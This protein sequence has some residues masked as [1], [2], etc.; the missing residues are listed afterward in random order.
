MSL[1]PQ[2]QTPD[3]TDALD[4]SLT[5]WYENVNN[6][7][8]ASE[9][10][11]GYYEY[12]QAPSYGNQCPIQEGGSTKIDIGCSR[13]EIIDLDNSYIDCTFTFPLTIPPQLYKGEKFHDN[14]PSP[15]YYVGFKSAFDV[16][17]QYRIYSNGDLIYT[18]NHAC[19]ESFIRYL[20]ITDSAKEMNPCFA[21]Q[22]K[23]ME[24]NQDV[25]GIYLYLNNT[26]TITY[27]AE[28]HM[29]IPVNAFPMLE[30]LK[31]YP[32][33][34]GK[35]SIEIYPSYKNLVWCYVGPFDNEYQTGFSSS[36]FNF[37]Q[38]PG[39][40]GMTNAAVAN[41]IHSTDYS[42]RGGNA[43]IQINTVANNRH[44]IDK[45]DA[46]MVE[47][48]ETYEQD[49]YV[50]AFDTQMF[51]CNESTLTDFKLYQAKYML[52]MDVYN[53]LEMNYLQ[54]PLL[55]P[56]QTI[57]NVK[58]TYPMGDS[59]HFTLQCTATLSHCDTVFVVFPENSNERTVSF[60]PYI[61]AQLSING[62]YYPREPLSTNGTDP[63]FINLVHDALN[64]NNNPLMTISKDV[65]TSLRPYVH[66]IFMSD[67]NH[68][69]CD[70]YYFAKGDRS[71]F[72]YAVPLSTNEDFMGG[73]SS[74]GS[75]VQIELIGD[76][77]AIDPTHN[78]A[79]KTEAPIAIFLEDK[80]IKF[81]S[82]K[83]PGK[84]QI[85]FTNAT[86]DQIVASGGTA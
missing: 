13:F 46:T 74:N 39:A 17:D 40:A 29:K 11:P 66:E 77:D 67:A 7:L 75:T 12:A 50:E 69:T 9:C 70:H 19:Y 18:Q 43:F 68:W 42:N 61:K 58:F 54:I 55:F 51:A 25:P 52:K 63:R 22:K 6:C 59:S 84:P 20:S 56:V 10:V 81:Y 62:K 30:H 49:N 64:I 37:K 2:N 48:E 86:L 28:I 4:G 21:T 32:G 85:Q 73:I 8:K 83:P 53:A 41:E 57:S 60:N 1:A 76:R 65:E 16:I 82:M 78:D 44:V 23:V 14:E 72:V 15:T 35:L 33:F 26:A 24:H 47:E 5:T 27:N 31:W 3:I 34:L 80:L 71:N 38:I 45:G 36:Y 79:M